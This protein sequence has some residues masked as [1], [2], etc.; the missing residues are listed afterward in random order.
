[1]EYVLLNPL[2]LVLVVGLGVVLLIRHR[3]RR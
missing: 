2:C 1:M 3:R